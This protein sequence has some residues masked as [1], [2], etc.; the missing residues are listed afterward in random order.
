MN[1][2]LTVHNVEIQTATVE[3]RTLTISGKQVTLAVF[4][5]LI[6]ERLVSW[7]GEFIGQPWGVVN[8][9]PD[10]TCERFTGHVHVVWQ[11]GEELRRDT[12]RPPTH[13][14][15]DLEP[16]S[17]M[18]LDAAL[19]AGWRPNRVSNEIFVEFEDLGLV[20]IQPDGAAQQVMIYEDPARIQV[21]RER[22]TASEI[23]AIGMV[24]AA[25]RVEQER[26][27]RIDARWTEIRAL[28]Q[29]F[30]AV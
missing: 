28:P 12:C 13:L 19:L 15:F 6:E 8:Y 22:S 10:K 18:W 27:S 20:R 5:Q 29:L 9:H 1:R 4:R 2:R 7:E 24:M 11:A 23:E 30:I 16:E 14:P 25:G 17:N 21:I 3:V 26:R